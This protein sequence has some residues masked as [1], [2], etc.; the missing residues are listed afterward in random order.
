MA[1]IHHTVGTGAEYSNWNAVWAFLDS[2]GDL[3]DDYDF[4]QVAE[5]DQNYDSGTGQP[6]YLYGVT[7]NG[8]TVRCYVSDANSHRGDPTRGLV[9]Q[10]Y[11][12]GTEII[13]GDYN[14]FALNHSTTPGT[15]E[16]I[17]L[18]IYN[19]I[20]A[21]GGQGCVILPDNNIVR[22]RNMLSRGHHDADCGMWVENDIGSTVYVQNCKI[23]GWMVGLV[24]SP[25]TTPDKYDAHFENIDSW[26]NERN[27]MIG[28]FAP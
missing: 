14:V 1:A 16:L 4:E 11:A 8:H 5:V 3:L 26:Q 17:N 23:W 15:L 21:E 27:I 10:I 2:L 13:A 20:D 28:G 19:D 12:G 9:T 18:K 25:I 6:M 22:V 24:S 7:L